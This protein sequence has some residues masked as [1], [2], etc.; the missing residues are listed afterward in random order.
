MAV[1]LNLVVIV[2]IGCTSYKATSD[3]DVYHPKVIQV[4][5][6]TSNIIGVF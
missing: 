4:F 2:M 5:R 3:L 1:A 6:D